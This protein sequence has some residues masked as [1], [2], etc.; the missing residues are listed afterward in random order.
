MYARKS[1]EDGRY[2]GSDDL[3]GVKNWLDSQD[4]EKFNKA[5]DWAKTRDWKGA[6]DWLNSDDAQEAKGWLGKQ[7][8]GKAEGWL[9]ANRAAE[10]GRRKSPKRRLY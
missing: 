8:W 1:R 10:K 7:A 6:K 2:W 4:T 5:K 9:T 3:S